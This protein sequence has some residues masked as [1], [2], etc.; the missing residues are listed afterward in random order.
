MFDESSGAALRI[1]HLN[2]GCM[3]PI[4]GPIF[5]GFSRGP[6]ACLICHCLLIESDQ[7]LVL[8]DTGFGIRDVRNPGRRLSG[9]F[10][11]FNNIELDERLTALRQVEALGY[12]R[13]DVRHIVMTHL[14]FDHAGGL[15]DFPDAIVHVTEAEL[16]AAW[17]QDGPRA[18]RRYPIE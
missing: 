15:E 13:R 8:V 14:D 6:K 18:R 12:S 11:Y 4:G 17:R 3:R 7:G 16:D 9:F 10:R 5:D 2:C 1:H